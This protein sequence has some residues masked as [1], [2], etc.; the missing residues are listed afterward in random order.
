MMQALTGLPSERLQQTLA[1]LAVAGIIVSHGQPPFATYTFKHALVQDA[2]Y[3]S[4]LRDRRRAIHLHLAEELEKDTAG[5]ETEPQL[6][7]WHFA[8]GGRSGQVDPLLRKGGGPR[9][10]SLRLGGDGEPSSQRA[11]SSRRTSRFDGE[12]APRTRTA[13]GAGRA[14]IDHEGS[15]SEAVRVTFER[16]HE[17]C[18]ALDAVDVATAGLR[19]PG[20]EL[21]L[22]PFPARK[23]HS[24]HRR[25]ESRAPTHRRFPGVADDTAGGVSRQPADRPFR[26]GPRR[27][28]AYRRHLRSGPRQPA[29]RHEH[30]R[31]EGFHLHPARHLSHHSRLSRTPGPR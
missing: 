7:G 25:D 28:A 30:A 26:S 19:R 1:E 29:T 18:T 15:G 8:E 31:S 23:D 5:E 16:A 13:V 20:I 17:L 9:D 27:D 2:A 6:I 3:A 14:L 24:I 21:S 22:H 11:S 10:R 4:L 12:A